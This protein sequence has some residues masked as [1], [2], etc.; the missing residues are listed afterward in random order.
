M[1]S[2]RYGPG[3]EVIVGKHTATAHAVEYTGAKAVFA[4]IDYITGNISLDEINKKLLAEKNNYSCTYG[5]IAVIW[6]EYLKLQKIKKFASVRRLCTC[7]WYK[8]KFM[9]EILV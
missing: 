8:K 3:D 6:I 9:L 2:I 5:W 1:S 7:T 4:D